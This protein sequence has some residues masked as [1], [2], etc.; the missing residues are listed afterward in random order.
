MMAGTMHTPALIPATEPPAALA[1]STARAL[2]HFLAAARDAGVDHTL[3]TERLPA[4]SRCFA[5]SPYVAEQAARDPVAR[6]LH[7]WAQALSPVAVN[8]VKHSWFSTL[9][10]SL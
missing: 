5:C 7:E 8:P 4:L 6:A 10:G 9:T 1:E 3:A 2:E